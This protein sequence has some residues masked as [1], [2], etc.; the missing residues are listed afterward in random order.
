MSI[1]CL[2]WTHVLNHQFMFIFESLTALL[3][4]N[5]R[6]NT[7][8]HKSVF[9]SCAVWCWRSQERQARWATHAQTLWLNKWKIKINRK[10]HI[11]ASQS[12]GKCKIKW[13][14]AFCQFVCRRRQQRRESEQ[15]RGKHIKRKTII[16]WQKFHIWKHRIYFFSQCARSA[17]DI[18]CCFFLFDYLDSCRCCRRRWTT[19]LHLVRLSFFRFVLYTNNKEKTLCS[20]STPLR[21]YIWIEFRPFFCARLSMHCCQLTDRF[22]MTSLA[23]NFLFCH[24]PRLVFGCFRKSQ[25]S[26]I[27][28]F[29]AIYLN[30]QF[31]MGWAVQ[32]P[33][34]L[35]FIILNFRFDNSMRCFIKR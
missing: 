4:Q 5:I 35:F 16:C 28:L 1:D 30:A 26:Y 21:L 14:F 27:A 23:I 13:I 3:E 7:S 9:L 6:K 22:S 15:E 17:R 10:T 25:Q 19:L 31:Q 8:V 18:C 34:L 2:F 29:A 11:K 24:T 33:R 32:Q 20:F 12:N